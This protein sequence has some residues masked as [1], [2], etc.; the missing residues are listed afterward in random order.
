L[1]AALLRRGGRPA[2][3]LA[4]LAA[5]HKSD[6]L[7]VRSMA[8]RWLATKAPAD[9]KV[10]ASTLNAHPH[11]ASETASEYL[12]AG[13]WKDG[14]D[15][16]LQAVA[17]APDKSK[18][19]AM[20]Y[21]YLGYFAAR[22]GRESQA[23]GYYSLATKMPAEYVFPFQSEAVDVL[24]HAMT[25][26]PKDARAP[27]YL[28]N[29]LFDWQPDEATRLWETAAALDP[30]FPMVHRNLG[31]AYS[32]RPSGNSLERAIASLEKA[33]SLQPN[34]PIHFY[35]LDQ[36]YDAA[37]VAPEKRLALLESNQAVVV[38]RDDAVN[39]EVGL[40]IALGKYG[41]AIQLMTGR[42]FAVWEGGNLNVAESWV[43]AHLLRGR[44]RLA[45][46]QYP[47]A[48][49]DFQ[50]AGKIPDNLPSERMAGGGRD[51]EIAY[52][53][54]EAQ[55][56][57]GDQA[58]ATQFWQKAAAGAAEPPQRFRRRGEG[59]LSPQNYYRALALQK[60]GQ[61]DKAVETFRR[62]VESAAQ[63]LE[64]SPA[65][66]DSGASF[67]V[68]QA[69]RESLAAAHYVSGLGYL[70]LKDTQKARQALTQA[71]QTDPAHLG[72]RLAMAG[73]RD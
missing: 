67:E 72:A 15:V 13:L 66:A 16:L 27:F 58:Q 21:Y 18:I 2:E 4:A 62:L 3:A 46:K 22:M 10:L 68:V 55:A 31:I 69:G 28:G 7:D 64:K 38:R 29:L 59:G 63:A 14:T 5:A 48:L 20:V 44:Q 65:R 36:L 39:R 17:A 54:G 71:L 9:A 34:Y 35:E 12:N 52:C 40:K 53:L 25:A 11:T 8:E 60:L 26:N 56:A 42:R 37:G 6:P 43:D 45:A 50:A 61:D 57:L 1:K 23:A 73:L 24:R 51:A 30:A 32:H 49:A 33:V 19:H 41:D 70:G 47:E